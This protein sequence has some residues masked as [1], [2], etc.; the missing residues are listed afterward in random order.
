VYVV[1]A[2][3]TADSRLIILFTLDPPP[4]CLLKTIDIGVICGVW[5]YVNPLALPAPVRR[6]QY[7]LFEITLFV[8]R[9]TYSTSV[10]CPFRRVIGCV[11]LLNDCILPEINVL[12]FGALTPEE[13]EV[14]ALSLKNCDLS[15]LKCSVVSSPGRGNA[16]QVVH[17]F[18][19]YSS[20][21]L[22]FVSADVWFDKTNR[23]RFLSPAI[24]L[25]TIG[26]FSALVYVALASSPSSLRR[27][28]DEMAMFVAPTFGVDGEPSTDT[29]V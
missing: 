22:F 17:E 6:K 12:P 3:I 10:Y 14:L 18:V 1:V 8:A 26:V 23:I 13:C 16:V 21:Y 5:E 11:R 28:Y 19:P 2:T 24:K 27:R 25:L 15:I 20:W 9:I 4:P 29:S 7:G